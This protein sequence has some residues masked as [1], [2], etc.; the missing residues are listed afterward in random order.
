MGRRD[1][2][3]P[4]IAASHIVARLGYGALEQDLARAAL[5][6]HVIPHGIPRRTIHEKSTDNNVAS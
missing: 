3:D 6:P 1:A 5:A 2:C 4:L